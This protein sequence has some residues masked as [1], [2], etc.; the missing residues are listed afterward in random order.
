MYPKHTV[1]QVFRRIFPLRDVSQARWW[2]LL[3]SARRFAS[4]VVRK[5]LRALPISLKE[6]DQCLGQRRSSSFEFANYLAVL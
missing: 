4:W 1:H 5:G 3:P 6:H 2:S